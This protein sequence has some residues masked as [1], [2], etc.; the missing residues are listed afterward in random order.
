M[1]VTY[2]PSAPPPPAPGFLEKLEQFRQAAGRGIASV[3]DPVALAASKVVHA[4]GGPR[5]AAATGTR[6]ASGLLAAEGGWPGAGI[7]GTGEALAQVIGGEKIDPAK[8]GVEAGFGAIPFGEVVKGG[9]LAESAIK[10]GLMGGAHNLASQEVGYAE[11][12]PA[13]DLKSVL[14]GAGMGAVMGGVGS[15][16]GGN[17]PTPSSGPSTPPPPLVSS[18]PAAVD[19]SLLTS[20]GLRIA[21]E[22]KSRVFTPAE[23]AALSDNIS[24]YPKGP[25][26]TT[27]G[28]EPKGSLVDEASKL[29]KAQDEAAT[30]SA[31]P[32]KAQAELIKNKVAE[33]KA[34]EAANKLKSS[35]AVAAAKAQQGV[36]DD[37]QV[38]SI[39]ASLNPQE[40]VVTTKTASPSEG[41]VSQKFTAAEPEETD[42]TPPPPPTPVR[43]IVPPPP[44]TPLPPEAAPPVEAAPISEPPPAPPKAPKSKKTTAGFQGQ[45]DKILSGAPVPPEA[46]PALTPPPAGASVPFMITKA[47][48]ANLRQLGYTQEAIDAMKPEAAQQILANKTA[49]STPPITTKAT[50]IAE[51][52]TG[53]DQLGAL[54]DQIHGDDA[55]TIPNGGTAPG[56]MGERPP[57]S[58]VT[59]GAPPVTLEALIKAGK[60]YEAMPNGPAKRLAGKALKDLHAS[61]P[62]DIQ[63]ASMAAMADRARA[64]AES[65]R[66]TP[67]QAPVPPKSDPTAKARAKNLELNPKG[68]PKG[69]VTAEAAG[70]AADTQTAQEGASFLDRLS[71]LPEAER[72]SAIQRMKSGEEGAASLKAMLRMAMGSAGAATGAVWDPLGTDQNHHRLLSALAGAG[73]GALSPEILGS[74]GSA[75]NTLHNTGLLSPLSV[76]KK[77]LGDMGGIA[78]AGFENPSRIP[79]IAKSLTNFGEIGRDFKSGFTAPNPEDA[80]GMEHMVRSS[81]IGNTSIPNPLSWAGKTMGG[82]TDATKGILGRANFSPEEAAKYT[83]TKDPESKLGSAMYGAIKKSEIAQNLSPFARIGINR[84]E[85]AIE[86][87]PF[88]LGKL[89]G[90]DLSTEDLINNPDARKIMAQ[91]LAGT[92]VAGVANSLTPE[93]WVKQHP[94][95]AGLVTAALGPYGIP[96]LFGMAMKQHGSGNLGAGMKAATKDVPGF[97]AIEDLQALG[98]NLN[99]PFGALGRNYV[100]GYTNITRPIAEGIAKYRGEAEPDV[101]SPDLSP[102]QDLFN[103]GLSNIPGVRETLPKM[104][105]GTPSGTSAMADWLKRQGR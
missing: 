48:E 93:N 5:A 36:L 64:N 15:K 11:G 69:T 68:S 53:A 39:K 86:R 95:E 14:T 31:G 34:H 21:A 24:K 4:M 79:D 100:S 82:L 98:T 71:Q 7:S 102:A 32:N 25:V 56:I 87:S 23:H 18:A 29:S 77:A 78:S 83:F 97:R 85:E 46:A 30:M 74:S 28:V 55:L 89:K 22:D 104:A 12:G 38:A 20:K 35:E 37:A 80:G 67:P 61:A 16:L 43:A 60:D 8:I 105:G 51:A 99:K 47:N 49:P 10:G 19:K 52:D 70:K 17:E 2:T 33:A 75:I 27:V 65:T 42:S 73:V 58:P 96:A 50:K 1:P 92:T 41:T 63:K 6:A 13:P 45:V 40:P 59:P 94:T 9:R 91:A 62:P 44:V 66:K 54:L 81:T 72:A 57:Q 88:G 84:L 76:G 101:K 3:T 90:M 26:A 103:Q